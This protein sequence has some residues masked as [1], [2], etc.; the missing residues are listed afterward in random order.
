MIIGNLK[1]SQ[2]L[3]SKRNLQRELLE[4]EIANEAELERRVRDF[5]DPN[6]PVPV[7]PQFRTNADLQKDRIDQERIAIKN[8]EDLGFDY[9]KGAD[10]VSW[11]SGSDIDRLVEFNANFK[12]I[13]K[14]LTETTNP[15]L[16]TLDYI[17]NYLERFFEDL[18]VSFGRKMTSQTGMPTSSDVSIDELQNNLPQESTI[19]N[20]LD[21]VKRVLDELRR[22]NAGVNFELNQREDINEK[23]YEK[24]SQIYQLLE[25][26]EKRKNIL[27][28][29][30]IIKRNEK[31]AI[32]NELVSRRETII[33]L[34]TMITKLSNYLNNS[35]SGDEEKDEINYQNYF[36][37]AVMNSLI[38][39]EEDRELK[40]QLKELNRQLKELRERYGE[41]IPIYKKVEKEYEKIVDEISDLDDEMVRNNEIIKKSR[42]SKR[43]AKRNK[44]LDGMNSDIRKISEIH[45]E[46]LFSSSLL[47][48][49]GLVIPNDEF[50]N[51]FK[52]SL[53]LLQRTELVKR[54]ARLLTRLKAPTEQSL[55]EILSEAREAIQ[56]TENGDVKYAHYLFIK[57]NKMLSFLSFQ[58]N[59]DAVASLN[60]NYEA[61][62]AK[63]DK[64]GDLQKIRQ[65]NDRN[66]A[67]IARLR[68]VM[69]EVLQADYSGE[70][71]MGSL[72]FK[73]GSQK[74]RLDDVRDNFSAYNIEKASDLEIESS[75]L[76]RKGRLEDIM[77][78]ILAEEPPTTVVP[79]N[80]SLKSLYKDRK[81]EIKMGDLTVEKDF[82]DYINSLPESE[83][84]PELIRLREYAETREL[85]EEMLKRS[86]LPDVVKRKVLIKR[87][88]K[89]SE[90]EEIA[91][92]REDELM[93]EI[94][95]HKEDM[96]QYYSDLLDEVENENATNVVARLNTMRKLAEKMYGA[97]DHPR[98]NKQRIPQSRSNNTERE[99]A[100]QEYREAIMEWLMI[101]RIQNAVYGENLEYEPADINRPDKIVADIYSFDKTKTKETT[102]GFGLAK[103]LKKHFRED[104]RELK[105]MASELN[106]HKKE[107]AR[108]DKSVAFQH[109]RI[110][111][112]KGIDLNDEPTYKTF[113]KYVIHMKHLK[114]KGVANFKYPSLGSIPSIKPKPITEEYKEFI[115]DVLETGKPNERQFR[116]LSDD[117]REHFERV[118]LGAGLL[119][120]FRMKRTGDDEDKERVDRFNVLR[121]EVLAGNNNE[122]VIK[123]LRG[124]VVRF[125]NEGRITRQEGTNMLMELSA[126]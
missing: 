18:D 25:D 10:L 22:M 8:M 112:G 90:E 70:I 108:I 72:S 7:A 14:D 105:E 32:K 55:L 53:P 28:S 40:K 13:K 122:N 27:E 52:I 59:T 99:N 101:N 48:L 12:G 6:K 58:K 51:I 93:G 118:C 64:T 74:S 125:I 110:K 44:I 98:I 78:G 80:K 3:A 104:E 42:V 81:V 43:G 71:E 49:L 109:K 79:P 95:R 1:S 106:R 34:T 35:N 126:I 65:I 45:S 113:G 47:S 19:Y 60:R 54:Y 16:L 94:N 4:L 15:K 62:I 20:L 67:E 68:E 102:R 91:K 92:K 77:K 31:Q 117:E 120:H 38:R 17:K 63:T 24:F 56:Q 41:I 46:G 37:T 5:K 36:K 9:N 89:A 82:E 107:E 88:K 103:S 119:E 33:N 21:I 66:E 96:L 61:E 29:E 39:K 97:K 26:I 30:E 57:I 116:R 124:L 50:L 84:L 114:G 100:I 2:D 87:K 23:E 11:L 111:V 121:G 115:I 69:V 85:A 123:E 76:A 83:I 86:V 73:S 75:K